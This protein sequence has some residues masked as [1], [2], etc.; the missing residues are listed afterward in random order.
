[1]RAFEERVGRRA[2]K[3]PVDD[4]GRESDSSGTMGDGRVKRLHLGSAGVPAVNRPMGTASC[5]HPEY[6]PAALAVLRDDQ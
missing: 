2:A 4:I 6:V 5:A 1:M 3:S